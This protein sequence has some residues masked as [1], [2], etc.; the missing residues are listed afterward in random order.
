MI[1]SG[2]QCQTVSVHGCKQVPMNP[3]VLGSLGVG[4]LSSRSATEPAAVRPRRVCLPSVR[5]EITDG[6]KNRVAVARKRG[7]TTFEHS[8]KVAIRCAPENGAERGN[9]DHSSF[10]IRSRPYALY[11]FSLSE[12]RESCSSISNSLR[13][14]MFIASARLLMNSSNRPARRASSDSASTK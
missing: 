8:Q 14:Q 5:S 4:D 11:A 6:R 10:A 9:L 2:A 1:E 13:S 12:P 3:A 7:L